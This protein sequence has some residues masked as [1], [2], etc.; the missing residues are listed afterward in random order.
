MTD[1]HI[2]ESEIPAPRAISPDALTLP[3]DAKVPADLADKR[4]TER[5]GSELDH[6]SERVS[7]L[8]DALHDPL[9]VAARRHNSVMTAL[10]ALMKVTT[11]IADEQVK[12]NDRLNRLEPTVADHT[13]ALHLVKTRGSN[14]NGADHA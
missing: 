3:P 9:G 12:I 14:G 8:S 13:A 6:L 11:D 4:D 5:G 10:G 7:A 1:R 2:P